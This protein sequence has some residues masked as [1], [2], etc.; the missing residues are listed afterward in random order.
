MTCG[1]TGR[2]DPLGAAAQHPRGGAPL[3][4]YPTFAHR[5]HSGPDFA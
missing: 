3:G 5:R 1:M 2:D 4:K